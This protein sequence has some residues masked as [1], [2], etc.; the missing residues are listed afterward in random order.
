MD[1]VQELVLALSLAVNASVDTPL[2]WNSL[3]NC[4]HVSDLESAT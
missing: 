3:F 2:G 4:Q 1:A